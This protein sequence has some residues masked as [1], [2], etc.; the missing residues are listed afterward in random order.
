MPVLQKQVNIAGHLV[1]LYDGNS[2]IP[3]A[4]EIE[5]K[6]DGELFEALFENKPGG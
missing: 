4:F 1:L 2:K 3:D 5:Y 6:I